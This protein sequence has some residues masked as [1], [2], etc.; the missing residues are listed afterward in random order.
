MAKQSGEE[1]AIRPNSR[2][3][4]QTLASADEV[5]EETAH[6]I[7]DESGIYERQRRADQHFKSE[8]LSWDVLYKRTDI[9]SRIY[10]LRRARVL[11]TIEKLS[12]PNSARVLEVGCGA[13]LT[14]VELARR[15]H[16]VDAVD[17]VKEMLDLT[18]RHSAEEKVSDRVSAVIG[19]VHSLAFAGNT[20]DLVLAIGVLPWLHSPG[21][22]IK[23]LTRVTK[24]EGYLIVT[25]ANRWQL[26][27]ILDPMLNPLL[28]PIRI[29]A[30]TFLR[31]KGLHNRNQRSASQQAQLQY[32]SI[33]D[34]HMLMAS[35]PL[36]HVSVVTVGFGLF[37]FLGKRILPDTLAI[38]VH[39]K[40]QRMA[41]RNIP[42]LRATG[43]DHI[44]LAR[45]RSSEKRACAMCSVN[46]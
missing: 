32:Y 21:R 4:R 18:R 17:T 25:S 16:T 3:S 38:W 7:A 15:G 41:D 34:V 27:H 24:P 43:Y 33:K 28:S 10:Q 14:T 31:S 20:Y 1:E 6:S 19:D 29:L 5:S 42:V 8:A 37:S 45:K 30:I 36:Q 9:Y 13:G 11:E 40:L 35:Q 12:L 22:A 44:V 23:E 2:L 39:E 46:S 26:S